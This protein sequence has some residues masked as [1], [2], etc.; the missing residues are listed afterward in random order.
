L[1]ER[2]P[3]FI[4]VQRGSVGLTEREL[5]A[6]CSTMYDATRNQPYRAPRA[7]RIAGL[8]PFWSD[9]LTSTQHP[10]PALCVGLL[11][12]P[13]SI[14]TGDRGGQRVFGATPCWSTRRT[15]CRPA[16]RSRSRSS[17][18]DPACP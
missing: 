10:G 7:A 13:F 5:P 1:G 17:S 4:A 14:A 8:A 6:D 15:R 12:L 9:R 2:T 3:F 11:R 18:G 16:R